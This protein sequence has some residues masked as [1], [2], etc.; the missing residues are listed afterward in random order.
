MPLETD[1]AYVCPYCGEE[2]YVGT[3]P[4]AGSR[5]IF[6]ED[7]PVC[8]SPIVFLARVDANGDVTIES[9]ERDV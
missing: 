8:C 7:C 4:S 2:N 6:T 5:Q 3:D 1:A 9:A